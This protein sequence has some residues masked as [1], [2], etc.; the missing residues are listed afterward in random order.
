M[1]FKKLLSILLFLWIL[2]P[3][4]AQVVIE[5]SESV[6][7][8]T[9][10]VDIK[11]DGFV[12]ISA[13]QMG[14]TYDTFGLQFISAGF[15]DLPSFNSA[16]MN[17]SADLISLLWFENETSGESLANGSTL[18]SL[19]FKIIHPFYAPV[20][21]SNCPLE[22]EFFDISLN[23]VPVEGELIN[24]S[25]CPAISGRVFL[26][27]AYDCNYNEGSDQ[28]AEGVCLKIQSPDGI[29][30]VCTDKDGNFRVQGPNGNYVIEMIPPD[31]YWNPCDTLLELL[32]A[33]A[34]RQVSL[35]LQAAYPCPM[36]QVNIPDSYISGCNAH[37]IQIE[38]RNIGTIPVN[39]AQIS[40]GLDAGFQ[41]LTADLPF[42]EENG[43]YI[44]EVPVVFNPLQSGSFGIQVQPDCDLLDTGKEFCIDASVSPAAFCR[45]P[46]QGWDG[47]NLSL[48]GAC[49]DGRAFFR[50]ENGGSDMT[51]ET[52]VFIFRNDKVVERRIIQ[53]LSFES[54]IIEIES[55]GT[56]ISV[57][58][59]QP[60]GFAYP[61]FLYASVDNCAGNSS[62]SEH[63]FRVGD[64]LPFNASSCIIYRPE[65]P[66][67]KLWTTYGPLGYGEDHKIDREMEISVAHK[68]ALPAGTGSKKLLMSSVID[69]NINLESLRFGSIEFPYTLSL[70]GRDLTMRLYPNSGQET[71]SISYSYLADQSVEPGTEIENSVYFFLSD[72]SQLGSIIVHHQIDTMFLEAELSTVNLFSALPGVKI[73]PNPSSDVINIEW[74]QSATNAV[75]VDMYGRTILKTIVSKGINELGLH[76]I[77]SG[78]YFLYLYDTISNQPVALQKIVKK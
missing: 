1:S 33:G 66:A 51:A 21:L 3:L 46:G 57:L 40:V 74:D 64:P 22:L 28:P 61:G 62:A 4:R 78:V 24:D 39:A 18:I 16:N 31:A 7:N 9:L 20:H 41:I 34:P 17:L 37:T 63:P 55:Q 58:V 11:V 70:N 67:E 30:Y 14:F 54:E 68:L 43:K 60:E 13:F 5:K 76:S 53:L 36:M 75:L 27:L 25:R 49:K 19:K 38:Y 12:N 35:G 47:S 50:I 65:L 73:F 32:V 52:S 6:S 56:R 59:A 71:I 44:F 42:T 45:P 2:V 26:D 23:E 48:T 15:A 72:G 8:D 10:T 29:S 69:P 77:P